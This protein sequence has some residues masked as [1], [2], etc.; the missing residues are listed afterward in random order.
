VTLG[1]AAKWKWYVGITQAQCEGKDVLGR[2][3]Y[4]SVSA[5]PFCFHKV[6]ESGDCTHA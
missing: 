3:L 6:G 5:V 1:T 2:S 4:N